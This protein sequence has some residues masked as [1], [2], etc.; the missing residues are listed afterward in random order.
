MLRI[1]GVTS[2]TGSLGS[3]QIY[4]EGEWGSVCVDSPLEEQ[5]F[6]EVACR[7]MGFSGFS[8][9]TPVTL[10]MKGNIWKAKFSCSGNE[11]S[12]YDCVQLSEGLGKGCYHWN[13]LTLECHKGKIL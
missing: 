12:I 2:S 6:T 10:L 11:T 1:K 13:D 3:L 4:H 9:L 8:K 5:P 7:E